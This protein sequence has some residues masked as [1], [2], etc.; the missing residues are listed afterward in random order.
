MRLRAEAGALG[1]ALQVDVQGGDQAKVVEHRRPQ[2][3]RELVDDVHLD[4][5]TSRCVRVMLR[6]RSLVFDLSGLLQGREAEVDAGQGLGDHIMQFT[7]DVLPFI[8]LGQD[9]LAG[10]LAQLHLLTAGLLEQQ[11][12]ALLARPERLLRGRA[13]A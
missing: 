10:Q 1:D 12:V 11:D 6:S 8:L 9:D 7:A 13:A 2:L 4:F 5:T 3:A